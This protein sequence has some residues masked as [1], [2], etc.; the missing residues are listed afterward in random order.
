[1]TDLGL[2]PGVKVLWQEDLLYDFTIK[3]EGQEFKTHK[4]VLVSV[5]R[6][7]KAMFGEGFMESKT[8]EIDLKGLKAADVSKI[9]ELIYTGD[10]QIIIGQVETLQSKWHQWQQRLVMFDRTGNFLQEGRRY[11]VLPDFIRNRGRVVNQREYIGIRIHVAQCLYNFLASPHGNEPIV[12]YRYAHYPIS[13]NSC[14]EYARA[15]T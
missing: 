8:N 2:A 6:Y 7:F 9:M 10:D 4:V 5:S 1:M 15:G 3:V 14:I 11:L 13:E 12:H